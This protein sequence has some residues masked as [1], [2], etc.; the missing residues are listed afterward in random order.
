MLSAESIFPVVMVLLSIGA[1][2]VY[3]FH[4]DVA[5]GAYWVSAASITG[6]TLFM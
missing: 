6:S 5:K 2:V 4:G 1:S 3:F